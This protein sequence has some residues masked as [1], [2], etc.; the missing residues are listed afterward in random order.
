V[1]WI[2][3]TGRDRILEYKRVVDADSPTI[4]GTG[5]I[6][7]TG[8]TRERRLLL[9]AIS[10]WR[11]YLQFYHNPVELQVVQKLMSYQRPDTWDSDR[12]NDMKGNFPRLTRDLSRMA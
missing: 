9:R 1:S 4:P 3:R 6:T 11:Y 8:L 10:A 12:A 7:D 5:T 2:K